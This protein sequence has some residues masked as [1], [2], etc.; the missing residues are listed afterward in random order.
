TVTADF[1]LIATGGEPRRDM[2]VPGIEL[3]ITS[4]EFF[5]LKQLPKRVAVIGGGYVAVELSSVFAALGSETTLLHRGDKILRGFD[6]EVRRALMAG[7]EH[8]G[9]TI[10]VNEQP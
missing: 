3:A 5:G 10:S 6:D 7:M 4:N 8:R 1:I 9:I 2:P